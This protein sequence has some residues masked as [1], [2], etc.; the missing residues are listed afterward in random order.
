MNGKLWPEASASAGAAPAPF[1]TVTPTP[2][3][4]NSDLVS[5]TELGQT[6]FVDLS[7]PVP[8][9]TRVASPTATPVPA[10]T[11]VPSYEITRLVLPRI[12]LETDVVPAPLVQKDDDS[13][14]WDVPPF[15]AGHADGTAGAGEIGNAVLFGHVTSR[16][17]GNVFL[18]LDKAKVDDEVQVFSGSRMFEYRVV[19]VHAVAR[20]DVSV[21]DPTDS[22][23]ISLITCTGT[24]NPVIWDY[25]QRLVVRAELVTDY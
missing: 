11:Q 7:T 4:Q 9:P 2:A 6:V 19:E 20:D 14:T 10:P 8:S 17:L 13:L 24:W 15:V 16:S 18:T 12:K 25:M 1:A 21:L 3:P 22:S 23:S 5:A